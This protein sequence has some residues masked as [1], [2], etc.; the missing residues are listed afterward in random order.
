M[1]WAASAV[2]LVLLVLLIIF[3]LQNLNEVSVTYFALTFTLPLGMAL[4]IAAVAGGALVT[5][6]GGARILQL[7]HQRS[8]S[9]SASAQATGSSSSRKP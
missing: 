6:A 5:I 1:V 7:R 3:I 9:R 2:G 4:L 8:Q